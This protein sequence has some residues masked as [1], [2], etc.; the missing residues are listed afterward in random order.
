MSADS[1]ARG[2]FG[3]RLAGS[4]LYALLVTAVAMPVTIWAVGLAIGP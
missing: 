1:I 4:V 3:R 2:L